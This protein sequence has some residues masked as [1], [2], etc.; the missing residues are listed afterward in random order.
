MFRPPPRFHPT[1]P[2]FPYASPFLSRLAH[3]H[4]LAEFALRDPV[5]APQLAQEAPLPCRYVVLQRAALQQSRKGPE[6]DAGEI[7]D[8][9]FRVGVIFRRMT[10]RLVL[11]R[12]EEHTSELQSLM[13]NSYAVFCL[14]KK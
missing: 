5:L 13:R 2:H 10:E 6:N 7:A 9:V 12:S 4:P 14:T 3:S 11:L 8:A 1:A